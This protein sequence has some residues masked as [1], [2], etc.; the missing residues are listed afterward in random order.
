MTVWR[1]ESHSSQVLWGCMAKRREPGSQEVKF[2]VLWCQWEIVT[3]PLSR[4]LVQA[5][6]TQAE[7]IAYISFFLV[8]EICNRWLAP[9]RTTARSDS[10]GGLLAAVVSLCTELQLVLKRL[11]CLGGAHTGAMLPHL[12]PEKTLYESHPD[13]LNCLAIHGIDGKLLTVE[14]VEKNIPE[15]CNAEYLYM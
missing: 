5:P 11:K 6:H 4:L 13:I 2:G 10:C 3:P 8:P 15:T 14:C 1:G 12:I 9:E 7:Y